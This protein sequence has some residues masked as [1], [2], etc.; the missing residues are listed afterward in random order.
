MT[1]ILTPSLIKPPER[2]ENSLE[3]PDHP[4]LL[5]PVVNTLLGWERP[6]DTPIVSCRVF[7]R[8][9][10]EYFTGELCVPLRVYPCTLYK[11]S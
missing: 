11:P 3:H 10:A 4:A 1:I 6:K 2:N 5:A 8:K 9:N 7:Y